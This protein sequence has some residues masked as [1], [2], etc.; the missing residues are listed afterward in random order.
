MSAVP[1]AF[2]NNDPSLSVRLSAA[3]RAIA[4]ASPL[5]F[6]QTYLRD[7]CPLPPSPM[8]VELSWLLTD[9][10][11]NRGRRLALAAPRGHAKSTLLQA[12]ILWCLCY[13]IET[14]IVLI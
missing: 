6:M 11:R 10:A 3:R 4:A 1:N 2:P 9:A 5:A 8:H 7:A 14:F 12:Y 13:K